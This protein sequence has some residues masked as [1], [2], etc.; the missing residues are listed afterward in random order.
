MATKSAK[1]PAG[2]ARDTYPKLVKAFRLARIRDDAHLDE[3][4]AMIDRLLREDLDEGGE[5]YLDV[6][7]DL[8]EAYEARQ[9]GPPAASEGDLLRLLMTSNNLSQAG[10][11]AAVG[12]AQSTVSAV[13]TGTRKLTK[14]QVL[15]IARHF[16]I[17]PAAFLP[18]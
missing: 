7:T 12:I 8:V 9:L 1:S 15:A 11:G 18:G 16:G 5:Q 2:P 17:S 3:A 13:V 4:L 6:L 14:A 10:L